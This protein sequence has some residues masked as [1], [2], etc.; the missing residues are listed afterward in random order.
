VKPTHRHIA[1]Y[2]FGLCA[3]AVWGTTGP[4]S[5]AL[6]AHG[7]ALT[8]IGFWRILLGSAAFA[9]YGLANRDLFRIDRRGLLLVGGVGGALVALFE[10]AYQFGIA[11]AGVAGA[12]AL[13]YLAPVAVAVLA[14]PILGERLTALR[15]VL[16]FVVMVGAWLTVRGGHPGLSGVPVTSL[17]VGVTG[18]L[19][20]AASYAGTTILARWAVPKYGTFK[21]LFWEIAGGTLLLAVVLPLAGQP[22]LPPSTGAAWLFVLAL[23]AGPVVLA[24]VFFFN[25]VKRI[26]AAPTA[27]AATIEPVVGALLALLLFD[28]RLEP[29][30]WVGLALVI[31]GVSTGYLREAKEDRG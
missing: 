5:T 24:N 27:V 1:G 30:G 12:A 26:D 23:A 13:L 2:L 29:L 11:G 4:L 9:L 21:V 20:A 16:A 15:L 22:P 31:F 10:V 14:K 17:L 28:Q 6:Y 19:L 25:A 7:A 8:G 18:G 3:G